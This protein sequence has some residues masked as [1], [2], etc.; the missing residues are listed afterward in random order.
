MAGNEPHNIPLTGFR[1]NCVFKMV[2]RTSDGQLDLFGHEGQ[3]KLYREFRPEYPEKM[4]SEILSLVDVSRRGMYVD[5]AC[6]SGQLTKLLGPHFM[7]CLGVDKSLEQLA[8]ISG[9][10]GRFRYVSGSAF[11]L[12]VDK[13]SVDLVTV[14][15]ALHW[16]L[17]YEQFFAEVLRVLKPGGVFVAVA[18][19]FPK[20]KNTEA[21]MAVER[22]YFDLLGGGKS[23]GSPGCWW[24]TN[25]PT[26]DGFYADV[27]FPIDAELRRS[28]Q[29]VCISLEHYMNYLRTLSAYRTLLRCGQSD[30]LPELEDRI[31]T[32]IVTNYDGKVIA[33]ELM[34]EIEIPFFLRWFRKVD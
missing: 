10:V 11:N 19:A 15:Q 16:L 1:P 30:P 32:A 34:L 13:D 33:S 22:F 27:P 23:N 20:L 21:Q 18:Y 29:T 7:E 8:Q 24:E 4:V 17:P 31:A 6:G 3:A 2:A 12:P 26:I 14:A 9:D 25:R 28:D 5:V